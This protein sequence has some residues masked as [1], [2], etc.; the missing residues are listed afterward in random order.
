MIPHEPY[1][2]RKSYQKGLSVAVSTSTI[3]HITDFYNILW[4]NRMGLDRNNYLQDLFKHKTNSSTLWT[5]FSKV[6][7]CKINDLQINN[8]PTCV[9]YMLPNR[10]YLAD[11]HQDS[12]PIGTELHKIPPSNDV[13]HWNLHKTFLVETRKMIINNNQPKSK[14][15]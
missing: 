3:K 9:V 7:D 5:K 14:C 15:Q 1:S 13:S 11:Q 2:S 12:T 10:Q 4:K 8:K 6:S